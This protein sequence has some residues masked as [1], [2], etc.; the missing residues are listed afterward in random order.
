MGIS[1]AEPI[2]SPSESPMTNAMRQKIY[3]VFGLLIVLL[4][5]TWLAIDHWNIVLWKRTLPLEDTVTTHCPVHGD[6][7]LIEKVP[8]DDFT[9]V[10]YEA[11]YPQAVW[12]AQPRL[13]PWTWEWHGAGGYGNSDPKVGWR[14]RKRCESCCKADKK[15]HENYAAKKASKTSK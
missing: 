5:S 7:L 9:N 14:M 8:V 3:T 12:K 10:S 1:A 6:K 4:G 2:E 11:G 13:F 15:W